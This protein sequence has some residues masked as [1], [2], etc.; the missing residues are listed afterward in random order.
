MVAEYK[1]SAEFMYFLFNLKQQSGYRLASELHHRAEQQ[2]LKAI[3]QIE[4]KAVLKLCL[5]HG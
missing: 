1:I 4:E 2:L 5:V 3:P